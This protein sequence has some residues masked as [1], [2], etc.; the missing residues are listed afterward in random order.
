M[1]QITI[2]N[3]DQI[4]TAF[5]IYPD[6]MRKAIQNA[7]AKSALLVEREAKILTPVR[8][9]RLR[10]S[11]LVESS[12]LQP[13]SYSNKGEMYDITPRPVEALEA[14]VSPHTDYAEV[15]HTRIP[16]MVGGASSANSKIQKIFQDA[17]N[18]VLKGGDIKANLPDWQ[19]PFETSVN[20]AGDLLNKGK[21]VTETY[22]SQKRKHKK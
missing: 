16:Y 22:I 21:G 10:S 15:V 3:L 20:D 8:T 6:Q 4:Q 13:T 12:T 17:V 2:D 7:V 5:K 18:S 11:I 9:G 1:F 14:L 19:K